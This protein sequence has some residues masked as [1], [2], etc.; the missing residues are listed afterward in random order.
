MFGSEGQQHFEELY[1]LAEKLPGDLLSADD[2]LN[3]MERDLVN[4]QLLSEEDSCSP[5]REIFL[6]E[7]VEEKEGKSQSDHG[8]LMQGIILSARGDKSHN[9]I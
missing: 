9:K 1:N 2:L 8:K 6:E 4:Q 3:A 7:K 5:G